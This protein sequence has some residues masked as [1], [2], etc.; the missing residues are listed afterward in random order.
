MTNPSFPMRRGPW[1]LAM[2]VV[3][4]MGTA[5]AQ[6]VRFIELFKSVWYQQDASGDPALIPATADPYDLTLDVYMSPDW[7][8]DPDAWFSTVATFRTP[9]G[10]TKSMDFDDLSGS[11]SF[12][13]GAVAEGTLNSTY[14]A[15]TYRVTL[16]SWITGETR[17]D[18]ALPVN[19]Y[20]PAPKILNLAE[21]QA[22]DPTQDFVLQ[23]VSFPDS[24]D[25]SIFLEIW[26]PST[27][28]TL[29]SLNLDPGET[30]IVLP[31]E[32]LAPDHRYNAWLIFTHWA[33]DSPSTVPEVY[34]GFEAYNFFT[35][36]TTSGSVTPEAP[37]ITRVQVTAEGDLELEAQ[38]TP[39]RALALQAMD[40]IGG[41]WSDLQ[42]STPAA[43]PVTLTVPRST[44]GEMKIFRLRQE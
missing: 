34:S 27:E 35:V 44:L 25:G 26:E 20:P 23:W 5:Q 10:R 4:V 29:F 37:T 3:L 9:G 14:G 11:Y 6:D 30:S 31:P 33:V 15:G 2:A 17:Y 28:Q 13:D 16:S 7:L 22:I 21:A 24:A 19:N 1:A 41:I 38:C 40:L 42:T 8:N 36:Q 32:T 39:Q 43:S 12:Y 18:V